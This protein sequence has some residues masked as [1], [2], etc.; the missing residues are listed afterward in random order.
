MGENRNSYR[1][2]VRNLEG[3]RPLEKPGHRL[4]DDIKMNRREIGWSG[5]LLIWLRMRTSMVMNLRVP[6]TVG[7][8]LSMCTPGYS[9]PWSW[10]DY[11]VLVTLCFPRMRM[12]MRM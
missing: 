4:V 10:L 9:V 1:I 6:Y 2:L 3:K 8:F 11:R 7:K 12:R 5:T